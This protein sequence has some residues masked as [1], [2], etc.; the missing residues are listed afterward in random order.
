MNN[1]NGNGNGSSSI[2]DELKDMI[3]EDVVE[4]SIV[5]MF[6]VQSL[7]VA[8][9]KD[10]DDKITA[11]HGAVNEHVLLQA[12]EGL[13][14]RGLLS[15]T[16]G[17][18]KGGASIKQY[19]TAK[20]KWAAS[21]E[22]AHI[23]SLLP[24][25][26]AT[27]EAQ[28]IIDALN[29]AEETGKGG[30]KKAKSRL[31]YTKYC[32][33]SVTFIT[34]QPLIGSQPESPYLNALVEKSP[35]PYPRMEKGQAIL[36]FWRDELTSAVVLTSDA[37]SGWLRTGLR[38]GFG[39]SDVVAQYV[40]VSEAIIMPT[41]LGQLSL[42]IIDPQTRKGLGIS[43]HEVLSRGTEFT[44]DFRIP[45]KGLADPTTFVSWLISYA[46]RPI[47]G[48]SP[49]RGKRFG[50]LEVI[51]YKIGGDSTIVENALNSIA[52]DISDPR[53]VK[54]HTAMLAKAKQFKTIFKSDGEDDDAD[55]DIEAD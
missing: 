48:I 51:D 35:Y 4:I 8:S 3:L 2:K 28:S 9:V 18:T 50:K 17:T 20:V 25:L 11:F 10:V 23:K 32:D 15:Y 6:F 1:G 12:M 46:P 5:A 41:S 55:T 13:R 27:P 30:T 22:V 42:P 37:I 34:K 21:P 47:R 44:I 40:A 36:R 26:T 33:V 38:V 24:A 39:L 45:K 43:T 19:K 29:G 14:A 7:G 52:N 49:A 16:R 54:L 31:G 53:A